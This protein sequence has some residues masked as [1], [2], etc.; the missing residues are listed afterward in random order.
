MSTRHLTARARLTLMTLLLFVGLS[1]LLVTIN[2]LVVDVYSRQLISL[3]N[4]PSSNPL[5]DLKRLGIDPNDLKGLSATMA[6][7]GLDPSTT[8]PAAGG[9]TA[10]LGQ[11]PVVAMTIDPATGEPRILMQEG[12]PTPEQLALVKKM[13]GTIS[14]QIRSRLLARLLRSSAVAVVAA[15][16]IAWFVAGRV[17]KAALAPVHRITD[18]ARTLSSDS[19]DERIALEGPDDELKELADT[20]DSMLGRLEAGF[21]AR[22]SFGAYASHEL[23]T[24]LATLRAEADLVLADHASPAESR[25]LAGVALG[26]VERAD[27]LVT[28][29]LTI[30][31]AEVGLQHTELVDVAAVAGD[32]A[33]E[34]IQSADRAGLSFDLDLGDA[35]VQG[36][37]SLLLSML[38]NLTRNAIQYNVTGGT[39]RLAVATRGQSVIIEV[40]NTGAVLTDDDVAIMSQP[41]HRLPL[42]RSSGTGHGLGTA[43]ITAVA[44]VHD[45]T[46][47]W[48]ARPSGGVR[49][50]V[51]LPSA[52]R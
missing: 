10:G 27:Q 20:F 41:F 25:R 14:A 1:V 21:E 9:P 26:T 28:S 15:A 7:A 45:G 51:T 47:A 32:V 34:V 18:L 33:G 52:T 3:S 4:G 13:Q 40:T 38:Q 12:G 17:A 31:R 22:R 48:Q 44:R 2:Y 6:P 35:V 46:V 5:E 50:I 43:I 37:R 19:L 23:R 49:A 16:A 29:L 30:S 24:P 36:D 11:P 42:A 39:V 8:G